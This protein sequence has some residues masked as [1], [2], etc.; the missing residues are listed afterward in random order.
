MFWRFSGDEAP[1]FR[2]GQF[3]ARFWRACGLALLL[4]FAQ[5]LAQTHALEHRPLDSL[6]ATAGSDAADCP[7]CLALGG[8]HGG[9]MATTGSALSPAANDVPLAF[10]SAAEPSRRPTTAHA[11]RAPPEN[12]G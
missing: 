7:Q 2:L 8:L 12:R 9:A 4:L 5:H 6:S 10:M 3:T 11:I 1:N